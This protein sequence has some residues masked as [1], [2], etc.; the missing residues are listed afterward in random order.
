M[1]GVIGQIWLF[2]SKTVNPIHPGLA[3]AEILRLGPVLDDKQ[4]FFRSLTV[5]AF[6]NR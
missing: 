6:R 1:L 2:P 5:P 3:C 4:Q